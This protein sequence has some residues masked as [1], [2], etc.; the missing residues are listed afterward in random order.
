MDWNEI[1]TTDDVDYFNTL[2]SLFN[3]SYLKEL[4]FVS[5]NYVSEDLKLQECNEPIARLL[6]Q[7]KWGNPSVIEMEFREILQINIKPSAKEDGSIIFDAPLHAINDIFYWNSNDV[8]FREDRKVDYTWI[9]AKQVFW[10][11]REGLLGNKKT[12]FPD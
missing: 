9:A 2:V 8:L 4:C 10:R 7:S 11:I 1:R 3:E 12:Y 6:F 5:G